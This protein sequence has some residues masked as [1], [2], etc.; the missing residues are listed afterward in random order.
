VPGAFVVAL[1]TCEI[2]EPELLLAP[3]VFVCPTLHAYVVPAK[4]LLR[5]T[6]VEPPEHMVELAGL[7][8]ALGNGLTDTVAVILPPTH[9]FAVGVMVYAAVPTAFVVFVKTSAIV[10]P[11]LLEPPLTLT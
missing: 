5:F 11:E 6:D 2:T 3:L 9:P 7:T 8:V 10:D 1:T 4:L